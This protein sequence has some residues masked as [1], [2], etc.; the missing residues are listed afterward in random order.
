MG[1]SIS[2]TEVRFG[3][4][5]CSSGS[6]FEQ[7]RDGQ[8]VTFEAGQGEKGPHA[9]NVRMDRRIDA[10]ME[11]PETR[12]ARTRIHGTGDHPHGHS[13]AH[14]CGLSEIV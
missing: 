4:A 7:L 10:S 9:E 3:A 6:V 11:D 8:S 13:G 1:T 12:G 5:P 2:C 14:F